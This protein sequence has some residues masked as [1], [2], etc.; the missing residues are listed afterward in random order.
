MTPNP[1]FTALDP[2]ALE[3][4]FLG[5]MERLTTAAAASL[6]AIAAVARDTPLFPIPG[7]F[8]HTQFGENKNIDDGV[9]SA[10]RAWITGSAIGEANDALGILCERAWRQLLLARLAQGGKPVRVPAGTSW[11][12]RDIGSL[13]DSLEPKDAKKIDPL[14]LAGKLRLLDETFGV[15]TSLLPELETINAVRNCLTHRLGLVAARDINEPSS[16][17][18]VIKYRSFALSATDRDGKQQRLEVPGTE[19]EGGSVTLHFRVPGERRFK[20]G[21][22]IELALA[23]YMHVLQTFRDAAAEVLTSASQVMVKMGLPV[24]SAKASTPPVTPAISSPTAANPSADPGRDA[25]GSPTSP[26][27]SQDR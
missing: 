11:N 10:S 21:D 15:R 27:Q 3:G 14:G 13:A 4:D 16:G 2:R 8:L 26:P 25:T 9:R 19:V 17:S 20:I 5:E 18:C 6:V 12:P 22:R 24:L 7:V 1:P 23:E